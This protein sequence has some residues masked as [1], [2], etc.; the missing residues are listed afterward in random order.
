[1][2]QHRF[3]GI[4]KKY[5]DNHWPVSTSLFLRLVPQSVTGF[6]RVKRLLPPRFVSPLT[7]GVTDLGYASDISDH[8]QNFL[9]ILLRSDITSDRCGAIFSVTSILTFSAPGRLSPSI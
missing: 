3:I 4:S 5:V 2:G 9:L 7:L 1:M 6:D 8:Y